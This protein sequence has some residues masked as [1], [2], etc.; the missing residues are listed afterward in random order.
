M[1][2]ASGLFAPLQRNVGG[3]GGDGILRRE[4]DLVTIS[5]HLHPLAETLLGPN[6]GCTYVVRRHFLSATL[7]DSS[8]VVRQVDETLASLKVRVRLCEGRALPAP[9]LLDPEARRAELDRRDAHACAARAVRG[10]VYWE[11]CRGG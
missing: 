5:I 1:E 2:L 11:V 7:P 8:P 10:G 3:F 9:S 4:H 6:I